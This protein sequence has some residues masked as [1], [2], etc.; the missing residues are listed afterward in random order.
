MQINIQAGSESSSDNI[1]PLIYDVLNNHSLGINDIGTQTRDTAL[2]AL[3]KIKKAAKTV[4]EQRSVFGAYQNQMEHA[5]KNLANTV[6]NTQHAE[7]VIRDTDMA[8]EMVKYS[9]N[10]ILAQAGQAMLAQANQT[11]QGVLSLLQ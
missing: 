11:N 3:D 10:N 9:N 8:A 5:Y 6:E 2:E 4:D 1:I 7:S